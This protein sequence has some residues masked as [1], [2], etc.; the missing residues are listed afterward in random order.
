[1]VA[2]EAGAVVTDAL[3]QPIRYNKNAPK[4]FGLIC[5]APGIHLAAVERL[6]G[7]AAKILSSP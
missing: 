5:C 7:R 6:S 1:L 4:D 2:Q 3:G